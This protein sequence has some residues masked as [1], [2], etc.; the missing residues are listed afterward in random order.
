MPNTEQLAH[1]LQVEMARPRYPSINYDRL[2]ASL[3][4]GMR[5]YVEHGVKPG[6]FLAAVLRHDLASAVAYADDENLGLLREIMSFMLFEL[7]EAC[8]GDA[9]KVQGWL[10]KRREGQ[11]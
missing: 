2:P 8:H 4:S 5:L 3:R 9:L 7:P 11:R 1:A 10:M 6:G